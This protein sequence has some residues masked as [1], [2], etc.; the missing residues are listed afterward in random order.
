MDTNMVGVVVRAR[1]RPF[2]VSR[3]NLDVEHIAHL[4]GPGVGVGLGALLPA[5]SHSICCSRG[6][7]PTTFTRLVQYTSIGIQ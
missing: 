6:Y 3:G 1:G 5:T 2:V 7:V 4:S